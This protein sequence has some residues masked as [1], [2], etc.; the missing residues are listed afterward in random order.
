MIIYGSLVSPFVRKLL[1][2]LGEPCPDAEWLG[3]GDLG[4]FDGPFLV[5][6]GR[7]PPRFSHLNLCELWCPLQRAALRIL[8]PGSSVPGWPMTWVSLL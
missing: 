6:H 7:K 5:L 8:S 3:T 1:G 2:Y 4:H